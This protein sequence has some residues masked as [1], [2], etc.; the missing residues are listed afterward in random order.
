MLEVNVVALAYCT[1]RSV[2]SMQKVIFQNEIV[3]VGTSI[4]IFLTESD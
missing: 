3:E 2:K 1:Q 4:V